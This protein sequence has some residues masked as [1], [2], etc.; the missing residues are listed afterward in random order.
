MKTA[1]WKPFS[2]A[3]TYLSDINFVQIFLC[4]FL[5]LH[6]VT[7]KDGYLK[8]FLDQAKDLNPED[9]GHLLQKSEGIINTHKDI[10]VEGQTEVS[11]FFGLLKIPILTS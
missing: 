8:E 11:S 9:R 2:S 5:Y 1:V 10:A 7:I 4:I 6:R 3:C